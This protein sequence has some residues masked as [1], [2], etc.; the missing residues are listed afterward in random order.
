VSLAP[1]NDGGDKL[2]AELSASVAFHA[3]P[4]QSVAD[5]MTEAMGEQL[6]LPCDDR[7]AWDAAADIV[8]D[9]C[10]TW[11][12]ARRQGYR[13]ALLPL[14]GWEAMHERVQMRLL[15]YARAG[16]RIV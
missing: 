13:W 4:G 9:L 15:K 12:V 10:S 5:A 14:D 6:C 11:R 8:S 2:V 1:A 16:G 7:W 3:R